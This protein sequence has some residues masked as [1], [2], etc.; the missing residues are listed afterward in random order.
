MQKLRHG[1]LRTILHNPILRF[2][3]NRW[4]GINWL[5][6]PP[7]AE[8]VIQPPPSVVTLPG[9]ILSASCQP[10][11][12]GGNTPCA[13]GGSG[14]VGAGSSGGYGSGRGIYGGYIGCGLLGRRRGSVCLLPC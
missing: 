1:Q 11:T 13:I 7:P 9:P 2:H 10:V 3:P 8:V 12:V 4:L 14:I 5:P 6:R